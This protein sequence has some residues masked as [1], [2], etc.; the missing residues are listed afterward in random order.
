MPPVQ[1]DSS[2]RLATKN[3]VER[4]VALGLPFAFETGVN[5]FAPRD[6]EMPDGDFFAAIA[7][8]ADCGI[9]L[10]LANLWINQKNGRAKITDVVSKLPLERVWEVHLAGG[11]IERGFWVDAH[12]RGI[13]AELAGLAAEVVSDL[14]NLGAIIFELAADRVS[15]FGSRAYLQEMETV[16]RLWEK[17]P[18]QRQVNADGACFTGV[19]TAPSGVTAETWEEILVR[20]M[21]PASYRA[22]DPT[23]PFAFTATDEERFSLYV[24][25]A[26]SFRTGAIA[27]LLPNTVRLLLM[28]IGKRA[29]SE[30]LDRYIAITPPASFPTDEAL[31][32]REFLEANPL[33]VS[34]LDEVLKFEAIL[35]QAAADQTTIRATFTK[36]I[37]MVLTGLA[38]GQLPGPSSDIRPT[39]LEIGVEPMPFIRVVEVE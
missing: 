11:E 39:L 34:G 9:L 15:T 16:N 38:A 25:L 5:Y 35:I 27:E 32:F 8:E 31:R 30:Y 19:Q 4:T 21:L 28:T 14:P 36:N 37:D 26:G 13:D 22:V 1:A 7:N 33:L 29:L 10:D 2:V 24:Y 17:V 23:S 18:Q 20:R 6:G 12:S 3:I